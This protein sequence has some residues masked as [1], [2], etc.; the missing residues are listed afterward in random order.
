M[1]R[2][3]RVSRVCA[4]LEALRAP[5]GRQ[6][7]GG[8][9]RCLRLGE[10]RSL[11]YGLRVVV[12]LALVLAGLGRAEAAQTT[13][14]YQPLDIPLDRLSLGLDPQTGTIHHLVQRE[15]GA[16]ISRGHG[17]IYLTDGNSR[18]ELFSR[19]LFD[20]HRQGDTLAFDSDYGDPQIRV[21]HHLQSRGGA[22]WWSVAITNTG[23]AVRLLEV[24]L[25]LPI[26]FPPGRPW[27]YWDGYDHHSLSPAAPVYQECT[28][29]ANLVAL[30][31]LPSNPKKAKQPQL[32]FGRNLILGNVCVFPLN[33]LWTEDFGLALGVSP[34]LPVSYYAGGVQPSQSTYDSFYYALKFVVYPGKTEEQTFVLFDFRGRGGYRA[35]LKKYYTLFPQAFTK[36]PNLAPQVA[37]PATGGNL[38]LLAAVERHQLWDLWAEFCRRYFIGWM[39]LYAPFVEP[40]EWVPRA[41]SYVPARWEQKLQFQEKA[42]AGATAVP[43]A[44]SWLDQVAHLLAQAQRT[45]TV[46]WYINPQRCSVRLAHEHYPE[47]I[48]HRWHLPLAYRQPRGVTNEPQYSMFAYGTSFGEATQRD[49]RTILTRLQAGGIA[50]DNA[51]AFEHYT[52]AGLGTRPGQAFRDGQP[53]MVNNL[54]YRHL[55]EF[56]HQFGPDRN[57]H[58]PA[59]FTNV[60]FNIATAMFTD[61][62]LI[63]Y[64]PYPPANMVNSFAALRYLLGPEKSISFKVHGRSHPD[65]MGPGQAAAPTPDLE[66]IY[67]QRLH[68]HLA[69]FRWG[70]FPRIS[71][72]LGDADTIAALPLLLDLQAAGWEP[73]PGVRA[74]GQQVWVERFGA[75]WPSFL[76]IINHTSR[77][78]TDTLV[79]EGPLGSGWHF[80]EAVYGDELLSFVDQCQSKIRLQIRPVWLSVARCFLQVEPA[81]QVRT[82][83]ARVHHH[84]ENGR[85]VDRISLTLSEPT[86]AVLKMFV[87]AQATDIRCLLNGQPVAMEVAAGVV[88]GRAEL[89]RQNEIVVSYLA[90]VPCYPNEEALLACEFSTGPEPRFTITIA[91]ASLQEAAKLIQTYFSYFALADDFERFYQSNGRTAPPDRRT[92]R[93]VP[94]EI[95]GAEPAPGHSIVLRVNPQLA[96][97]GSIRISCQE[98]WCRIY[99]EGRSHDALNGTVRHFLRLLDRKY[100]RWGYDAVFQRFW[101][102]PGMLAE[103]PKGWRRFGWQEFIEYQKTHGVVKP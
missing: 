39:W 82:A 25:G 10:Q 14:T 20:L 1:V 49:I 65:K 24:R 52:G 2:A 51:L 84:T 68:S 33:C 98:A 21:R 35:A 6:Y 12:L 11:W 95:R 13:A 71:E 48:I 30:N 91:E 50:F 75:A 19:R 63:E 4:A 85:R 22:V 16:T 78:A 54:A 8:R 69:L 46:G 42:A 62:C 27:K 59:V 76:T 94:V 56:V 81:Q 73:E 79:L 101:D 72:A 97:A 90:A 7:Q 29:Q 74:A 5:G 80:Y 37:L 102:K 70:A 34:M 89:G 32:P 103:G 53:Y 31:A 41:E 67:N 57:G 100:A 96:T 9:Y 55:Q 83:Q 60:P 3:M 93:P 77:P 61:A 45:I 18:A 38:P 44:E 36:R 23:P 40:G 15:T 26:H 86:S 92:V 58:R 88:S 47:A 66:Q 99:V 28:A 43:T 64:H 17:G 87:G